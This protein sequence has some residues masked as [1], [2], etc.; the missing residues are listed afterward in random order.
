MKIYSLDFTSAP[1]H[2]KPV[3]PMVICWMPCSARYKR[4]GPAVSPIMASRWIVK[5][6]GG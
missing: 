6:R 5:Q 4:H 3:P 2:R 1:D